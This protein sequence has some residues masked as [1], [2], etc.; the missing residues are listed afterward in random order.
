M[1]DSV[2]RLHKAMKT[3]RGITPFVGSGL[4]IESTGNARHASWSGLILDGIDLCHRTLPDLRPGWADTLRAHLQQ[5]DV[6]SYLTA[7]QE[8]S[9]RLRSWAGGRVFANWLIDGVG[10]LR[11]VKRALPEAVGRLGPFI[12]TTNYDTIIERVNPGLRTVS[13]DDQDPMSAVRNRENAVLHLHGVASKPDSVVL[14]WSDYQHLADLPLQTF[15]KD[16][17]MAL[18]TLLF[19]CCGAGLDDPSIGPALRFAEDIM[20][21]RSVEHFLLVVG[22]DLRSALSRQQP[23]VTPV[24]YGAEHSEL[25][26]F[27]EQLA[28]GRVP[29]VIQDPAAYDSRSTGGPLVALLDLAGPADERL[30]D[31]LEDARRAL[32]AAGQ[33]ERRTASPAGLSGWDLA[34]QKAVLE[35]LAAASTAPVAWLGT[36]VVELTLAIQD[37]GDGASQLLA[38][39]F[40]HSR[41]RLEPLI[42]TLE[43]V[44]SLVV[45]LERRLLAVLADLQERA[46][47]VHGYQTSVEA[48]EV[49][50]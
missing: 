29:R 33:L 13:W 41:Q 38:P 46:L 40:E 30:G 48:Y 25:A 39:R 49:Y 35:Q 47:S 3:G 14:G 36:S 16:A 42:R 50:Y 44:D 15:A 34:D 2:D 5:G 6:T 26:Y 7:A 45:E 19:I 10:D 43:E 4:S 9:V 20:P 24:A 1:P 21:K 32:R 27:L 18:E 8:V 31:A 23:F 22:K 37:A 28:D 12:L 11:V 17:M